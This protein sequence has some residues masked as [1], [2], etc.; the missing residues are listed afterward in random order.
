M[1]TA[2][3]TADPTADPT[4]GAIRAKPILSPRGCR[5]RGCLGR[6][7][8]G[9]AVQNRGD[10][11][12]AS[13][14][15]TQCTLGWRLVELVVELAVGFAVRLAVGAAVVLA[16]GAGGRVGSIRSFLSFK[17]SPI[18]ILISRACILKFPSASTSRPCLQRPL[19]R[20]LTGACNPM[21]CLISGSR[22]LQGVETHF[23]H[24]TCDPTFEMD[25]LWSGLN[26][27]DPF[28]VQ[29]LP[30]TSAILCCPGQYHE[31]VGSGLISIV[32][33]SL[34]TAGVTFLKDCEAGPI[35][36]N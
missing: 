29:I 23:A 5:G 28:I 20:M 18:R 4:A 13:V 9:R 8:R 30:F 14:G 27:D 25:G 32:R 31:C 3:P 2:A 11:H 26:P 33:Q 36:K 35:L 22:C 21:T 17:F 16:V 24:L 7:Y 12:A 19:C 6:G 34:L 1:D 10:A 15:A